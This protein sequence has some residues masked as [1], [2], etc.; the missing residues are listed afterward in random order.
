MNTKRKYRRRSSTKRNNNVQKRTNKKRRINKRSN[1]RQKR[2]NRKASKV[3]LYGG[4]EADAEVAE[5]DKKIREMEGR[6]VRERNELKQKIKGLPRIEIK[7]SEGNE[8]EITYESNKDL[9]KKYIYE[10]KGLIIQ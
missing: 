2:T 1:R 8:I 9:L 4:A 6:Q 3:K 10:L 5:L 7:D